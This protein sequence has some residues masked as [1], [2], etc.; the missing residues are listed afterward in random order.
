MNITIV[1]AEGKTL[2][3]PN[4]SE[5]QQSQLRR[6]LTEGHGVFEFKQ[7]DRLFIVNVSKITHIEVTS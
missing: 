3:V 2:F 6:A 1:M 7:D 4:A 5:E